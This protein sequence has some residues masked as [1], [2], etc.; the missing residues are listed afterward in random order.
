[1]K[2]FFFLE[3]MIIYVKYGIKGKNKF[4]SEMILNILLHRLLDSSNR[5]CTGVLRGHFEG[6]THINTKVN[7]FSFEN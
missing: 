3:V 1:M 5:K 4:N 6:I 2:I 7:F